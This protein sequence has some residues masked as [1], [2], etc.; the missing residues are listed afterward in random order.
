MDPSTYLNSISSESAASGAQ[1]TVPVPTP[2][3]PTIKK[4]PIVL[5]MVTVVVLIVVW[6]VFVGVSKNTSSETSIET[7]TQENNEASVTALTCDLILSDDVLAGYNSAPLSGRRNYLAILVDGKI[8]DVSQVTELTFENNDSAE[9]VARIESTEYEDYYKNA[10]NM[11]EDPF[12]SVF[13]QIGNVVN[14]GYH[15]EEDEIRADA[16]EG[17][18]LPTFGDDRSITLNDLRSYYERLGYSCADMEI[19]GAE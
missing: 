19:G 8:T 18:E 11:E 17:I 6:L 13:Q 2:A 9:F 15:L 10:L 12:D 1:S 4:W 14:I 7:T 16:I 3:G 5:L